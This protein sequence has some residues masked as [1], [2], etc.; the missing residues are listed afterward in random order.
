[1]AAR[2]GVQWSS[3]MSVTAED[4]NAGVEVR[5]RLVLSNQ[6]VITRL[7][8]TP[9]GNEARLQLENDNGQPLKEAET[10][11]PL[12]WLARMQTFAL[13]AT[14]IAQPS[15]V[16]SEPLQP[17]GAGLAAVLDDL[18]DNHPEQWELLLAEMRRWLPEYDHIQFDK[19]RQGDKAIVLRTKK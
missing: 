2:V 14:A 1:P 9:N 6:I 4:P 17:N 12:K 7:L 19:P 11:K 13:D 15:A 10:E 5:L 16:T 8:W 18:K 3:I